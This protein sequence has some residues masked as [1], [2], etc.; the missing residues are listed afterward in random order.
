MK[1]ILK[2]NLND[3]DDV[4]AYKRANKSLD[5]ALALWDIIFNVYKETE[6]EFHIEDS[7]NHIQHDTLEKAFEKI[8]EILKDKEINIEN[9]IN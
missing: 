3:P 2:Y 9:L 1:A 6:R 8:R 7:I 4:M 5:M